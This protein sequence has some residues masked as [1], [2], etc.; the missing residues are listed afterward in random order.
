MNDIS[1]FI[2]GAVFGLFIGL[3]IA[4]RAKKLGV[5]KGRRDVLKLFDINKARN[6]NI[7]IMLKPPYKRSD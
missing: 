5:K 4:A 2:F 7:T 3:V 6:G 1:I